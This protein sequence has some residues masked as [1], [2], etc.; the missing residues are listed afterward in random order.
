[1]DE[2]EI[3]LTNGIKFN[4]IHNMPYEGI[5]DINSALICWCARTKDYAPENF[6]RYVR[7]KKIGYKVFTKTQYKNYLSNL[8]DKRNGKFK[9]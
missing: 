4:L 2:V 9:R 7:N 1:M 6:V 5:F 8:E 3:E